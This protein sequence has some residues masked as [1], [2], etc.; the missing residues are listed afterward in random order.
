M[1]GDCRNR[2]GGKSKTLIGRD[3]FTLDRARRRAFGH[4]TRKRTGRGRLK[5][6]CGSQVE[7][8]CRG[9]A[10]VALVQVAG[11][12]LVARIQVGVAVGE[13][14][15]QAARRLADRRLV[16]GAGQRLAEF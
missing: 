2:V 5:F 12:R 6:F 3:R 7:R 14:K 16:E 13:G 9:V 4:V 11:R 15:V 10:V 8:S 1:A